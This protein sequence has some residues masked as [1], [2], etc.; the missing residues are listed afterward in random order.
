MNETHRAQFQGDRVWVDVCFCEAY[1]IT[2]GND[3]VEISKDA[4]FQG[5]EQGNV[6]MVPRGETTGYVLRQISSYINE[7]E[8]FQESTY[9]ADMDAFSSFVIANTASDPADALKRLLPG[10]SGCPSLHDKAF[11]VSINATGIVASVTLAAV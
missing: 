1:R 10:F 9:D 5:S 7:Y 4:L 2:I 8:D 6:V 3:C 11:L